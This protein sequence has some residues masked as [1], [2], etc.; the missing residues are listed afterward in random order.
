[1]AQFFSAGWSFDSQPLPLVVKHRYFTHQ[2]WQKV[3][4][5]NRPSSRTRDLRL[6]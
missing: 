5:V 6:I 1:M 2:P 3:L 4:N